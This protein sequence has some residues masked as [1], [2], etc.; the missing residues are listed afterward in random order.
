VLV[1]DSAL[2]MNAL[3]IQGQQCRKLSVVYAME[4]VMILPLCIGL[5]SG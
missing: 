3:L 2:S 1:V 4:E 5:S